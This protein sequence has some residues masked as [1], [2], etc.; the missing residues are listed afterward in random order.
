MTDRILVVY[1]QALASV[2]GAALKLGVDP[3]TIAEQAKLDVVSS[4]KWVSADLV[5]DVQMAIE[6][7]LVV[8]KVVGRKR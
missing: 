1:S 4:D 2:F 7:A 6:D 8:A 3:D 5:G